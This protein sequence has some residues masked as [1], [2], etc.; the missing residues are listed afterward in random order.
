[1]AKFITIL[2]SFFIAAALIATPAKKSNMKKPDVKKAEAKVEAKKT[3]A[4]AEA[5]DSVKAVKATADK[6]KK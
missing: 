2:T 6:K 3:E 1:M 4:K 5:K